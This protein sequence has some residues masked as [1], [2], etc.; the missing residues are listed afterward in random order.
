VGIQTQLI[1]RILKEYDM[2]PS[3]QMGL[4]TDFDEA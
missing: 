3:Q 1:E 4:F 2:P